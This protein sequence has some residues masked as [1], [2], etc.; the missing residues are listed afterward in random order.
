[1]SPAPVPKEEPGDV[2][3]V[4]WGDWILRLSNLTPPLA[5]RQGWVHGVVSAAVWSQHS[6]ISRCRGLGALLLATLSS[7]FLGLP[8]APP[9][10]KIRGKE[11]SSLDVH[12][13]VI[14]HHRAGNPGF[15][16]MESTYML[17]QVQL[18]RQP[19]P[20]AARRLHSASG[21]AHPLSCPPCWM[22]SH[23]LRRWVREQWPSNLVSPNRLYWRR[24]YCRGTTATMIKCEITAALVCRRRWKC[25]SACSCLHLCPATAAH[26][27]LSSIWPPMSHL[28]VTQGAS[29]GVFAWWG[30]SGCVHPPAAWL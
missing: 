5:F 2:S 16:A 29:R 15:P 9:S 26:L 25:S 8:L 24:T 18:H 23:S 14:P 21:S 28:P 13:G 10:N 22:A 3:K 17:L 11:L 12:T 30:S 4:T 7:H 1:M 19:W 20:T 6:F 27:L